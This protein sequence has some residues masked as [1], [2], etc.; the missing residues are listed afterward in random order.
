MSDISFFHIGVNPKATRFVIESVKKHHPNSTYFLITDGNDFNA[1]QLLSIKYNCIHAR[2]DKALGGPKQ[3]FGYD[4]EKILE[5]LGRF[6]HACH[7]SL[8]SKCEHVMML[9]DD[10]ILVNPVTVDKNWEMACHNITTGNEIPDAVLKMISDFSGKRPITNQYGAGGGSIFNAKTFLENY[11][12]V[13]KFFDN[14]SE[15][16]MHNLYPTFGW[17][18]CFMVIYYMLCGKDYQRNPYLIDTNA[19]YAGF[20]YDGFVKNL[21]AEIQIVNNY[22]KFYYE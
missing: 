3:P 6:K 12:N 7:L 19:H 13:I 14:H 17:I 11:D 1:N 21:P 18:D 22:K 4:K 20:D 5:F 2:F 10:V 9:E 8:L 15:Y 16:I